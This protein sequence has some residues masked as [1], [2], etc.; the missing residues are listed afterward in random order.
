MSLFLRSIY[1]QKADVFISKLYQAT[2]KILNIPVS[3]INSHIIFYVHVHKFEFITVNYKHSCPTTS[4]QNTGLKPALTQK[5]I[6]RSFDSYEESV[7]KVL[8]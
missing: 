5:L 2:C 6:D 4:I 8:H 3:G 7:S 1:Y